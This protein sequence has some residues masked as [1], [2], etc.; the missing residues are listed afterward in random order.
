MNSS[1][2][3][4]DGA[5]IYSRLL[6]RVYDFLIMGVLS[7][8]VWRCSPAHYH[9]LYR[10]L[11]S[12]NHAD[13]GVG[14]GY[15]L[16][17]CK[18]VPGKLR[19]GLFDLQKN[20][21]VHSAR[22][23]AR[24]APETYQCNALEPLPVK[25]NSFDSIGLG[26]ILHCIPGEMVVKGKVFDSIKS[27]MKPGAKIFGY[28]ILNQGVE[29]TFVSCLVYGVLYHLKVIN[30]HHDSVRELST[31]LR[32]RFVRVETKVIGCVGFFSAS[33]PFNEHQ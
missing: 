3:A 14:T 21:L 13:I 6:L 19:L 5:R 17:Q 7:P 33:Q 8:Y 25:C 29:K 2:T 27:L 28:T 10:D 12:P 16:N 18:Y 24:F 30:G 26:G 23:L 9:Q 4:A 1:R 20:C 22:R 31:E 11:M 15:C 32:K